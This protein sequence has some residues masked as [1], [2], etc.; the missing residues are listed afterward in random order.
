MVRVLVVDD[1][2]SLLRIAAL[3]LER[4]GGFEVVEAGSGVEAIERASHTRPD[5]I[6]LD[7]MMPELDGPGTLARL[8]ADPVTAGIPIVFLTAKA[9]PGEVDALVRLGALGVI[10]KPFDPLALSSEVRQFLVAP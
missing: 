2:P 5:L 1:D 7:V 6:L 3:A 8:R 10:A 9:Q 4:L